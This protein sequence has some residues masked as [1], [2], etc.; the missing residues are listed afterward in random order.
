MHTHI[1]TTIGRWCSEEK[2]PLL[3]SAL[4]AL[5]TMFVSLQGEAFR[6]QLMQ[7]KQYGVIVTTKAHTMTGAERKAIVRAA[8]IRRRLAARAR[9]TDVFIGVT[10]TV[11]KAPVP[12]QSTTTVAQAS[13]SPLIESAPVINSEP[14]PVTAS[15][16]V[17]APAQTANQES[18]APALR[19]GPGAQ[20]QQEQG[21]RCAPFISAV[22][23][24]SRVPD[25]GSMHTPEEWTKDYAHMPAT[26]Y[27]P[28]PRY[29]LQELTVPLKSLTRPLLLEN[30]SVI[31]AK[32]YYST[33]YFGAYDVDATEFTGAHSG[34]DLK[35]P[36][37]MPVGAI[38]GGIV[39]SVTADARLGLHVVIRHCADD[40]VYYS[41]YGHFDTASVQA[42]DIVTPGQTIGRVGMTGMT[43]GP[44]VHLQVDREVPG[45]ASPHT[46]YQPASVP[47][48]TEAAARS[49]H[50][51]RFIENH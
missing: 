16:P 15:A 26:A 29:N 17:P 40:G 45:E 50:P 1:I 11:P 13:E 43:T 8:R 4:L 44:H 46:P 28:V 34:I 6:A 7:Q 38:A 9:P 30:E 41:V 21:D 51:I 36:Q 24:V 25:W 48:Q 32:L 18:S 23:P 49:V 2:R 10:K 12:V 42:G 27:V 14:V 20:P 37:G 31:T 5:V 39:D 22:H 47:S 33:R 35:L 19:P 3:G